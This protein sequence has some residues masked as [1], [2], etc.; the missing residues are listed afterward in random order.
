MVRQAALNDS[1]PEV[2]R[3]AAKAIKAGL[4]N[5][6]GLVPSGKHT[7]NYGTSPFFYGKI[8]YSYGKLLQ[9]ELE[10]STIFDGKIHYFDWVIFNSYVTNYQRVLPAANLLGIMII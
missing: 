2:R 3:E 1:V 8:H 6:L 10:R 5:F 7:K 4:V 9:N